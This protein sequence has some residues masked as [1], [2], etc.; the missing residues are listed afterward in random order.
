MLLFPLVRA[1]SREV[2]VNKQNNEIDVMCDDGAITEPELLLRR[3]RCFDRDVVA[4]DRA[5]VRSRGTKAFVFFPRSKMRR[6]MNCAEFRVGRKFRE[7]Q[8]HVGVFFFSS[9]RLKKVAPRKKKKM[10]GGVVPFTGALLLS[11]RRKKP[12]AHARAQARQ[13]Q[14][15]GANS[16][17]TTAAHNA[18]THTHTPVQVRSRTAGA[19]SA[20]ALWRSAA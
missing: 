13:Q 2:N 1:V 18:H 5:Q 4:S 14:R 7:L 19:D 16:R 15:S 12:R 3:R 10:L 8:L 11:H 20:G 6:K 9:T 17:A